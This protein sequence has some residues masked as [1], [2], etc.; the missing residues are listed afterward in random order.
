MR[1]PGH[2]L[3]VFVL[4]F[5]LFQGSTAAMAEARVA[6]VIGNDHYVNLDKDLQLQKAGND[7]RAVGDALEKDGF[8]VIRGA[9]LTR[10]QIVD[11]LYELSTKLHPGDTALFYFAGHGVAL[12]SGNFLLP[13]DVPDIEQGQELRLANQSVAESDVIATLQDKS[14]RVA[15]MILDA[16]RDN[17]FRRP[18]LRSVG[19]E[20]GFEHMPEA[21]GVFTLYS[22][23]YGQSAL[24]RLSDTDTNPNSVFTRILVPLLTRP[25]LNLDDLSFD[26]RENV[27]KLAATTPDHHSQIPAAYNQIVGGRVYLVPSADASLQATSTS[28]TAVPLTASAPD[29][30]ATR[31]S[32]LPPA[33]FPPS[34]DPAAIVTSTQTEL[35]RLGCDA[36]PAN[37]SWTPRSRAAMLRLAR[38]RDLTLNV[39][40]PDEPALHALRG[41]AAPGCPT[42]QQFRPAARRPSPTFVPPEHRAGHRVARLAEAQPSGRSIVRHTAVVRASA[43][44]G[45]FSFNGRRVCD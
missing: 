15:I 7:A 16:C 32:E 26:V 9:D 14:V 45:C 21:N 33:P 11:K 1:S 42:E 25:G 31:I 18:G 2:W 22:A 27:A 5:L 4:G 39:D 37:G 44:P 30:A 29:V 12:G 3:C 35:N 28:P 8:T 10:A 13:T 38:V 19:L 34:P 40:K 20:R 41:L 43:I 17:P 36:G 23:G 6:L 24:D